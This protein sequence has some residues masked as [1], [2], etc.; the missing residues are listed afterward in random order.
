MTNAKRTPS[1]GRGLRVGLLA[2]VLLSAAGA[3]AA[4]SAGHAHDAV[5][6]PVPTGAE[7]T[8]RCEETARA[9]SFTRDQLK[10]RTVLAR[11]DFFRA[12]HRERERF[13]ARWCEDKP[14][15]DEDHQVMAHDSEHH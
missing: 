8:Q 5:A 14:A 9:L 7:L 12:E 13:H 4:S 10:R 3:G 6:D 15:H 11:W 1:P 2:A